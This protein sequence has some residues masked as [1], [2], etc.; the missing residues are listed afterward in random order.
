MAL[1]SLSLFYW[2]NRN[3]ENLAHLT[4]I[5]LWIQYVRQVTKGM[6]EARERRGVMLYSLSF[7]SPFLWT[8]FKKSKSREETTDVGQKKRKKE[9]STSRG[10]TT[11]R[12]VQFVEWE[13]ECVF[14]KT[15]FQDCFTLFWIDQEVLYIK[16]HRKTFFLTLKAGHAYF[17]TYIDLSGNIECPVVCFVFM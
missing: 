7:T 5:L 8:C 15:I 2:R 9:K 13:E 1:M 12:R 17:D 3:C 14:S 11:R 10:T 6:T 4:L 16:I